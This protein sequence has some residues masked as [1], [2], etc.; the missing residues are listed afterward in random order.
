MW[1]ASLHG[2]PARQVARCLGW[3]DAPLALCSPLLAPSTPATF[4]RAVNHALS[5]RFEFGES[6]AC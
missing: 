6:G 2:G 1:V 4:A 5:A 3:S